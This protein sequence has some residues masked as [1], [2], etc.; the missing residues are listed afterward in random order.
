MAPIAATVVM[1][2]RE[3]ESGSSGLSPNNAIEI[4]F[5]C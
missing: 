2:T 1:L 5:S 4:G 3:M